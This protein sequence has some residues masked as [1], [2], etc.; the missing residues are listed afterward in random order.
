MCAERGCLVFR[1]QKFTDLG[2]E[3]QKNI[4]SYGHS[5]PL[6]FVYLIF[7]NVF[8]VISDPCINMAGCLIL[9]MAPWN[10]LLF[11]TPRSGLTLKSSNPF[12]SDI[13]FL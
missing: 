8:A 9:R 3:Q 4:A 2:F 13:A 12:I 10:S 7:I 1:D 6:T 11:M 5:I